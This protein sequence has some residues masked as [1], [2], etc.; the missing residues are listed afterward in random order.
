M[1][2][3]DVLATI[4]PDDLDRKVETAKKELKNKQ[5]ELRK[6]IDKSDKALELLKAQSNYDL[7]MVQKQTLPGEQQLD[8]QTKKSDLL[9]TER[10][11]KDKEKNL[12]EAQ[13]DYAELLSGKAG[14]N[15]AELALSKNVRTRNT[16]MEKLIRAFREEASKLQSTLDNYDRLIGVTEVFSRE[17][18]TIYVKDDK[19]LEVSKKY[20]WQVKPYVQ[21]LNDLYQ[22]YSQKNVGEITENEMLSAYSVYKDI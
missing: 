11:I 19:A 5:L 8:V 15:N 6:I 17:E 16:S 18:P 2:K 22:K 9:E 12:K 14:A 7:L 13:Q 1:K 4:T 20:F 3:G 21:K 10:L